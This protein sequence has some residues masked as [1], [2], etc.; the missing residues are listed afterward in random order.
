MNRALA[1]A[2][3]LI[4]ATALADV[5]YDEASVID[6][7]PI[8][9]N[10]EIV[11]PEENCWFERTHQQPHL[12]GRADSSP[13]GPLMGALIGGAIGNAVGHNKR[14]KQVGAVLGAALGGSIAYDLSRRDRVRTGSV[15]PVRTVRREVC[16]VVHRTEVQQRVT[17]YMVTYRYGGETHRARLASRPGQTIRVRVGVTPA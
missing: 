15:H 4:P 11:K 3:A 10:V 12:G 6:V 5:R 7:E 13:T 14:N 8:M 17:G 1:F 9:E 16:E 2:L